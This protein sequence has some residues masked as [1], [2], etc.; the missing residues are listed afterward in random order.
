MYDKSQVK[1]YNCN[2]FGHYASERG[3]DAND[4]EEEANYIDSS[5]NSK[6]EPTLLLAYKGQESGEKNLWYLDTGASNHMCGTKSMLVEIDE[7][8]NG[9]ITF[10]DSFQIPS[11]VAKCLKSY[12]GDSSW[13]WPLRLGHLHFGG[14]I[15]LS[16]KEMVKGLPHISHPKQLWNNPSMFKEFKNAMAQEFEMTN[17]GLMSYYLGIEVKQ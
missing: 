2:N 5:K 10:G 7:S 15:L 16:R 1:C 3:Y 11:D 13:L 8:I 4:T 14:L 9:K 17:I 12:V 6:K